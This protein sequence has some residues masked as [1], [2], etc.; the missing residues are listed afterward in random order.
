[1]QQLRRKKRSKMRSLGKKKRSDEQSRKFLMSSWVF[2]RYVKPLWLILL[3]R[4]CDK[5]L[6]VYFIRF[7]K[8]TFRQWHYE[9]I[10]E[11]H[12]ERLSQLLGCSCLTVRT[13]DLRLWCE[14]SGLLA[15][16]EFLDCVQKPLPFDWPWYWELM[17]Q[18]D[19][20][21]IMNGTG[22]WDLLMPENKVLTLSEV[23][24]L[25]AASRVK[26]MTCARS[27]MLAEEGQAFYLQ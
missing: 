1:M 13:Q 20:L 3:E 10:F 19:E 12:Q 15:K 22:V 2:E 4:R 16:F 17:D 18:S 26:R 5:A 21:G 27:R 9:A 6:R 25:H 23:Q 11:A 24:Q 7:L 8:R 14:K